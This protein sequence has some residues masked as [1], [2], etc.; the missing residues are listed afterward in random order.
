[1]LH[2][3]HQVVPLFLFLNK[4]LDNECNMN[5]EI[6]NVRTKLNASIHKALLQVCALLCFFWYFD[7]EKEPPSKAPTMV[8]R[9]VITF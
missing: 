3:S 9:G 5:S 4:Y 6:L 7:A 2:L 1:M 8:A